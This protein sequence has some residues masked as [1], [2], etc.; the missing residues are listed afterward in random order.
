MRVYRT[1]VQRAGVRL[2]RPVYDALMPAKRHGTVRALA[3][4]FPPPPPP[5]C[6]LQLGAEVPDSEIEERIGGQRP[7]MACSLIY[8]SGTTGPPKAVMISHDNITWT[9]AVSDTMG[10]DYRTRDHGQSSR[11]L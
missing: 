9:S 1:R 11:V 2:F 6:P 10:H 7:G 4:L 3:S 8:T 5:P